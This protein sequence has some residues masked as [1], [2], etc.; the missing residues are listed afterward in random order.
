[1]VQKKHEGRVAKVHE[2]ERRIDVSYLDGDFECNIPLSK[3]K[4]L[5]MDRGS[6]LINCNSWLINSPIEYVTDHEMGEVSGQ[7][8]KITNTQKGTIIK[9][10]MTGKKRKLAREASS[11]SSL[12][13]YRHLAD[14]V[15][16]DYSRRSTCTV[17]LHSGKEEEVPY[18]KAVKCI[19]SSRKLISTEMSSVKYWPGTKGTSPTKASEPIITKPKTEPT[20]GFTKVYPPST[21]NTFVNHLTGTERMDPTKT[22]KSMTTKTKTEPTVSPIKICPPSTINT[23]V[24]DL[25]GTEGMYPNNG[26]KTISTTT[27]TESTISST[28]ICPPSTCLSTQVIINKAKDHIPEHE[29]IPK[30]TIPKSTRSQ[31]SRSRSYTRSCRSSRDRR[32]RSSRHDHHYGNRSCS[33]SSR[34][35]SYG[36]RRRRRR[37]SSS[38]RRMSQ[39]RMNQNQGE[40]TWD[41]RGSNEPHKN[42]VQSSTFNNDDK[43]SGSGNN[44]YSRHDRQ[45]HREGIHDNHR[46]SKVIM[47][48]DWK[49]SSLNSRTDRGKKKRKLSGGSD[50]CN[51][52]QHRSSR[53]VDPDRIVS[54]E[55]PHDSR[56]SERRRNRADRRGRRRYRSKNR[57]Q[58]RDQDR[59]SQ[60]HKRDR[61]RH[62]SGE[63]SGCARRDRH[64]GES[65]ESDGKNDSEICYHDIGH[66]TSSSSL[67]HHQRHHKD[68]DIRYSE[69]YRL[70]SSGDVDAHRNTGATP[71]Q[72]K[73]NHQK[74]KSSGF[75]YHREQRTAVSDGIAIPKAIDKATLHMIISAES[76]SS[77]PYQQQCTTQ[78]VLEMQPSP[79]QQQQPLLHQPINKCIG[80]VETPIYHTTCP[81]QSAPTVPIPGEKNTDPHGNHSHYEPGMQ[82]YLPY[83]T[84]AGSPCADQHGHHSEEC[85]TKY[86]P[87]Y[88]PP[89]PP[90]PHYQEQQQVHQQVQQQVQQQVHQH[91]HQ[92]YQHGKKYTERVETQPDHTTCP[93]Q[94]P[95]TLFIPCNKP[96]LPRGNPFHNQP[97]I[98]SYLPYSIMTG[99]PSSNI[100]QTPYDPH[101]ADPHSQVT[102]QFRWNTA[103]VGKENFTTVTTTTTTT[104]IPTTPNETPPLPLPTL[105]T[106]I[107][108]P[109]LYDWPYSTSYPPPLYGPSYTTLCRRYFQPSSSYT[110]LP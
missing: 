17:R 91:Q 100:L 39:R 47:N 96:T 16:I 36:R 4:V 62:Y 42:D 104:T 65:A 18:I 61:R 2:D 53:S 108:T 44:T 58:S 107:P 67:K 81:D 90:P 60:D 45:H 89:Q 37:R 7:G 33:R 79:H 80:S 92:Q 13:D 32:R 86:P 59:Y 15:L 12:L 51:E 109:T 76:S 52:R 97:E 83:L 66:G 22:S 50:K 40:M 46:R 35:R 29:L 84:M 31:N 74:S 5:L 48:E 49:R 9:I 38:Q 8:A 106:P 21:T 26:L 41:S 25:L 28:K 19:I 94:F 93:D 11:Q 87:I 98:Q 23:P 63:S 20:T 88:Q 3:G 14:C 30:K 56:E 71:S 103:C 6:S 95:P 78:H 68:R 82:P 43:D 27:K 70:K 57:I 34:S 54:R 64:K 85:A 69:G 24:I 10:S 102:Q 105:N 72:P 1:M 55:R 101:Y 73:K 75:V 99:H 110:D 77:I